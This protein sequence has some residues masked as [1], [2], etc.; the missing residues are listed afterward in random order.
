M[1]TTI[2][3]TDLSEAQWGWLN[4]TL[5]TEYPIRPDTAR[6]CTV[7]ELGNGREARHVELP[8][9]AFSSLIHLMQVKEINAEA[10][11][12]KAA[13]LGNYMCRPESTCRAESHWW[14]PAYVCAEFVPFDPAAPE[15]GTCVG[16]GARYAAH[17][18]HYGA[19]DENGPGYPCEGA[20]YGVCGGGPVHDE[21]CPS[22]CTCAT[23]SNA[24]CTVMPAH[25]AHHDADQDDMN[26]RPAGADQ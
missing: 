6:V 25:K 23:D 22:R 20:E 9:F 16:C 1:R 18:A 8:V 26:T 13:C 3:V 11:P 15:H 5:K 10:V 17:K 14:D 4:D 19:P 24:A 7:F 12:D 21:A 2:R